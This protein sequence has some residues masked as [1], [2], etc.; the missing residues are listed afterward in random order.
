[1]SAYGPRF[2]CRI[3]DFKADTYTATHI[4]NGVSGRLFRKSC[5]DLFAKL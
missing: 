2:H 3:Y 5:A 4:A 1:M